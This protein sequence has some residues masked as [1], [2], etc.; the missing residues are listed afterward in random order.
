MVVRAGQG[1]MT[2]RWTENSKDS[3]LCWT[4]R[5]RMVELEVKQ[6]YTSWNKL[7]FLRRWRESNELRGSCAVVLP[8]VIDVRRSWRERRNVYA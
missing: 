2:F 5:P 8:S 1:G 4:G 3:K 7:G 6:M